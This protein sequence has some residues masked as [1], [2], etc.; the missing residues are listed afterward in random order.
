MKPA[1]DLG[2][3][4]TS[5][6]LR[7]KS[8]MPLQPFVVEQQSGAQD[9]LQRDWPRANS[10]ADRNYGYAFQWFSMAAAVLA[11]MIVHGVRRYR[12]LSGASPTD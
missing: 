12:R 6:R 9:G 3:I 4:S 5:T 7:A 2:R 11:L 8:A 10:G 1:S